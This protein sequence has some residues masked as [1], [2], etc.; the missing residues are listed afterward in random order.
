MVPSKR[1]TASSP[2]PKQR[3]FGDKIAI[4][5]CNN[6]KKFSKRKS[7]KEEPNAYVEP[8]FVSD[9]KKVQLPE[10]RVVGRLTALRCQPRLTDERVDVE[11][12]VKRH[13]KHEKEEKQI[14]RRLTSII[15]FH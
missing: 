7:T 2:T 3:R 8:T 5:H 6:D 13:E 11:A 14:L 4:H 9:V 10:V 1:K 12:Y 15:E